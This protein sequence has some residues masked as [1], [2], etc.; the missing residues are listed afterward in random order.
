[1]CGGGGIEVVG[2]AYHYLI[3]SPKLQS[4][5]TGV[6]EL[7]LHTIPPTPNSPYWSMGG[8]MYS[9][10]GSDFTASS[11]LMHDTYAKRDWI[12]V[13]FGTYKV[14]WLEKERHVTISHNITVLGGICSPVTS[15]MQKG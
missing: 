3:K 1:M 8:L 14:R 6:T 2:L 7:T 13:R 12:S 15:E 4:H 9:Y 10:I 11:C 5:D